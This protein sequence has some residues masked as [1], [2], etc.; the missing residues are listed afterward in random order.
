M[1][2]HPSEKWL[3]GHGYN[4]EKTQCLE[5]CCL[6]NFV[7]WTTTDQVTIASVRACIMYACA[8]ACVRAYACVFA[9][10]N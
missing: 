10:F 1:E 7:K 5:M 6:D 3:R 9:H 4:P 8:Y 2:Y